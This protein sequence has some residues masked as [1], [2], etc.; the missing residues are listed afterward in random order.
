MVY[1]QASTKNLMAS[2]LCNVVAGR[3]DDASVLGLDEAC[4]PS[5]EENWWKSLVEKE[6]WVQ[7]KCA[8][9][10]PCMSFRCGVAV[11]KDAPILI[12]SSRAPLPPPTVAAARTVLLSIF[13]V[14]FLVVAAA[15]P[16]S[17]GSECVQGFA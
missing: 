15:K 1:Q 17:V 13:A 6:A 8:Q 16:H 11:A 9:E 10:E 2:S 7:R 14:V 5:P 12:L 4:T 3:S